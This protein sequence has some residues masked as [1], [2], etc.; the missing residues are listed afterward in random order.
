MSLQIRDT[1]SPA[2]ARQARV[3][4]NR[5]PILEAMGL[6]FVSLS[7]RAFSDSA[8]RPSPWAPKKNGQPATL[9]K[10]GAMWQSIR[11]TETTANSVTSGS[12]RKYAAI[13]QFGGQAGRGHK[14]TIPPR[15]FLP[16]LGGKLT[17]TAK[18]K[19]SLVAKA[20]IL[21]LIK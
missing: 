7:K 12:D 5:K 19:I 3:I 14:V 11:I 17:P 8:L 2:L 4:R 9:R 20:K 1:I 21:A 10:S 18:V 13:H 16:V 15:P 6:E